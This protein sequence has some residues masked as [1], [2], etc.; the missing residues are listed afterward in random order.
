M[1]VIGA[2]RAPGALPSAAMGS[3]TSH[4]APDVHHTTRRTRRHRMS[5]QPTGNPATERE[6]G[7][8]VSYLPTRLAHAAERGGTI[9]FLTG[10]GP[11]AG[12]RVEWAVLHEEA[13]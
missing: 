3:S 5:R 13:K 6:V 4:G 9:T 8:T 1:T 11:S 7:G 12:D 10:G 2:A